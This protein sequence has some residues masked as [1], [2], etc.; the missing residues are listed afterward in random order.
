MIASATSATPM[1]AT[2]SSQKWFAGRHDAEPD[3]GRPERPDHLREA[4]PADD[5]EHDA[6]DQRVGRVEARHRRVR[7]R[8]ELDQAAA[9]V[10][11]ADVASV[12]TKPKLGN[13]RGGAVGT[14]T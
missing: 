3:P 1:P 4:V 7:V 10:Q 2:M 6:D 14:S 13:I 9:V 12:S 11:P 8:R 5:A